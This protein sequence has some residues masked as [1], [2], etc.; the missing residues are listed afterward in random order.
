MAIFKAQI[1]PGKW[2]FATY[3][4]M[5]IEV[6]NTAPVWQL[7]N[8]SSGIRTSPCARLE[9]VYFAILSFTEI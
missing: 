2:R 5:D 9:T 3:K 6:D 1:Q 8:G 7:G 4:Y